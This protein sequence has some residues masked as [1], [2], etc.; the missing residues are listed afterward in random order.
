MEIY[1]LCS[2]RPLAAISPLK[3]FK[4][5]LTNKECK[6]L[7]ISS[8]LGQGQ[9]DEFINSSVQGIDNNLMVF[10]SNE[11]MMKSSKYTNIKNVMITFVLIPIKLC[12]MLILFSRAV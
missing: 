9:L 12:T 6:I 1:L 10:T 8:V 4:L 3:K 5:R 11:E 7:P 2:H